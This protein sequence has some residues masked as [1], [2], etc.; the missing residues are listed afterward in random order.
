[1]SS[2]VWVTIIAIAVVFWS[3]LI[4]EALNAPLMPDDYG[5]EEEDLEE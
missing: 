2:V 4:Y 3:W 5:I 1:M